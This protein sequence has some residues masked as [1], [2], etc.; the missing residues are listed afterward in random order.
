MAIYQIQNDSLESVPQTTFA[1]AGIRERQDLQRFL[2]DRIEVISPDTLVIAEEFGEWEDSKRRIDLLGIDKSANL[3]VIELKRTEDGGV[4][5][6][7]AIRYAAMVSTLTFAR[8]V[9]VFANYLKS[10]NDGRDAEQLLLE[11]LEWDEA[12]NDDFAS[13]VRIVLASAEFSRELTSSVL[14]LADHGIDIRCVRIRPYID[15]DRVLLDVQQVIP[16]PE[17]EDYQI[18][19]REKRQEERVERQS[20][21][22]M[23]R[24]NVTVGGDTEV[25]LPK[26]RAIHKLVMELCRNGVSPEEVGSVI[27]W[28]KNLFLSVEG[29][30][31]SATFVAALEQRDGD[32]FDRVRWFLEDDEL[33]H[34]D[35]KTFALTNQWGNRTPTAMRGLLDRFQLPH[36]SFE[37]VS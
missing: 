8:A 17:A 37:K 2:R 35:S 25:N 26:R 3:V 23:S 18:R 33:I 36:I 19:V 29:D 11:F 32:K 10:R 5:E 6:L 30:C 27:D 13:D 4:M 28:R 24:F 7:Q 22:D 16:L 14:W 21:R 12:A 34:Y 20:K 31:E 15:R 1:A 9:E